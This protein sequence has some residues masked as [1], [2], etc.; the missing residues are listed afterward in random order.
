MLLSG[1]WVKLTYD[2]PLDLIAPF[3][4][5]IIPYCLPQLRLKRVGAYSDCISFL[6]NIVKNTIVTFVRMYTKT[7]LFSPLIRCIWWYCLLVMTNVCKITFFYTTNTL[8]LMVLSFSCGGYCDWCWFGREFGI[9]HF[10]Q[11]NA[12]MRSTNKRLR[13]NQRRNR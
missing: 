4:L 9:S 1:Q 6:S 10:Q 13:Q 7:I 3:F 12:N 8:S 2:K 5:M 11:R